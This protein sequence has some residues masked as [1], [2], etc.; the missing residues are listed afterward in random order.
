M[1]ALL[2]DRFRRGGSAR[3]PTSRDSLLAAWCGTRDRCLATLL[4][5]ACRSYRDRAAAWLGR[6]VPSRRF[7]DRRLEADALAH[8]VVHAS[9]H[10]FARAPVLRYHADVDRIASDSDH[11]SR[12]IFG[13]SPC[14]CT[15]AVC[16]LRSHETSSEHAF[17]AGARAAHPSPSLGDRSPI[18]DARALSNAMRRHCGERGRAR[19]RRSAHPS[20]AR[21]APPPAE[22]M[23]D[24]FPS[25][26]K[27]ARRSDSTRDVRVRSARRKRHRRTALASLAAIPAKLRPRECRQNA[28]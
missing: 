17:P 6:R 20:M 24:R 11:W 21:S 28:H 5:R 23:R 15:R 19:L 26:M 8:A 27:S 9:L 4:H 7:G 13:S 14:T 22:W 12:F 16:L 18:V 2:P 10:S 25:T 3:S 1:R